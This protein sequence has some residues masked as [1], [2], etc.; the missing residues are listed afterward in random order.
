MENF[1]DDDLQRSLSDKSD[2]EA[3]NDSEN[4]SKE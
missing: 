4:E 3:D 2:N 1:A